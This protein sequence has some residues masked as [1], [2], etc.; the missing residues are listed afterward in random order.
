MYRV[1]FTDGNK[2]WFGD[3]SPES[4]RKAELRQKFEEFGYNMQLIEEYRELAY[5]DGQESILMD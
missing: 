5:L 3:L 1:V 2:T 4:V